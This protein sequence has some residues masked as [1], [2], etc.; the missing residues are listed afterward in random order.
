M[1]VWEQVHEHL[2]R[3]QERA[4]IARLQIARM[5]EPISAMEDAVSRE[6]FMEQQV[7]PLKTPKTRLTLQNN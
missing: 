4:V 6:E 2:I 5:Q 7:L 3:E 1:G